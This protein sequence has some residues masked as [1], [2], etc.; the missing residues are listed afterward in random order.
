MSKELKESQAKLDAIQEDIVANKKK[1]EELR[2]EA[3]EL[4]AAYIAEE[5]IRERELKKALT[6]GEN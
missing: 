1:R 3:K 2:A 5:K 6:E 4:R